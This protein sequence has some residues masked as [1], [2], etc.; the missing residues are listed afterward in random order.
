MTGY[1]EP[2]VYV[3]HNRGKDRY[4]IYKN[5]NK[6]KMSVLSNKT[7]KEIN[8]GALK[9]KGLEIAWAEN[10]IEAFFLQVQGSGRLKFKNGEI[11]KVRYAGNNNKSYT[12]IGKILIDNDKIKK[13]NV[14]MYTIKNWLY[15]NKKEARKVMEKNERY[16]Y[17]E[18]YKG[19]IRGSASFKLKP[20]ISIAVDPKFHEPGTIFIIKSANSNAKPFLAIAHDQGAAIKGKNRIDLFTGSGKQAEIIAAE[21]N[22]KIFIWKLKPRYF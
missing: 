15:E 2:E 17:F 4:P 20:K 6:F 19:N 3:F 18:Q 14:S 7:R 22:K 11:I 12:S 21:L 9:N 13:K 1:Y 16:I 5:P 8:E 10:E